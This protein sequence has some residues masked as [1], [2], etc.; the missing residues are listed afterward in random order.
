MFLCLNTCCCWPMEAARSDYN[1]LLS[2]VESNNLSNHE[3]FIGPLSLAKRRAEIANLVLGDGPDAH[4]ALQSLVSSYDPSRPSAL[5]AA[6]AVEAGGN[7]AANGDKPGGAEVNSQVKDLETGGGDN[8]AAGSAGPTAAGPV[9]PQPPPLHNMADLRTVAQLHSMTEQFPKA[10][11][12]NELKDV[13]PSLA[14]F[15]TAG[16]ALLS[17]W[18]SA[19]TE[20]SSGLT[21]WKIAGG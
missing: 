18:K 11:S 8:T 19:L 15:R 16:R 10:M 7:G 17:A 3:N 1:D 4:V 21:S 9:K 13:A 12:Q 2:K 6:S 20:L 5:R 14:P